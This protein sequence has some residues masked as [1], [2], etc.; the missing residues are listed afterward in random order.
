MGDFGAQ[1]HRFAEK[2]GEKLE[3]VDTSFKLS[4]FDRVVRRTRVDT[5]RM[6]GN[7]QVTTNAPATAELQRFQRGSG[8]VVSEAEKIEPFSETWLANNVPYVRIW[9]ERDGMVAAA[10][11][12][13]NRQ[14]KV[15]VEKVK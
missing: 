15:A 14:L 11:A 5:G 8:L 7:R 6:R 4:L 12:D 13:A 10:I 2:T 9:E 1:L 3:D